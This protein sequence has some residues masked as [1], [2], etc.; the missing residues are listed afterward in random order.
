MSR[1]PAVSVA[2]AMRNAE[3]TIALTLQSLLDQSLPDWELL[4]IDDGSSDSSL[5]IARRFDDPRILIRADG[6]RLGLAARLNE[7]V[8]ASRGPYIA[9][10]DADD[11]A[12]PERFAR[13]VGFLDRH[14]EVDLLGTAA[15]VFGDDGKVIGALPFRA[16][17]RE[18]AARP[19]AGFYLVHPTWMGRREWF[20]A[21]AYDP[22]SIKSQDYDLLLRSHATSRFACLPEILLGYRQ[23]RLSLGKILASR[24]Q[25]SRSVLRYGWNNKVFHR[26]V[27][28]LAGQAA[29]FA[30]DVLAVSSGLGYRM[31]RHRALAVAPDTRAEWLKVWQRLNREV[32]EKCAA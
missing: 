27:P 1:N 19:W 2:M 12:Y 8:A 25:T 5:A 24:I 3:S 6:R 30:I 20:N 13:Q 11:V 29:K 16:S 22:R 14:P 21:H 10:M 17:H 32:D 15:I 7:A 31:L 23:E 9:R 4:L 26:V 28:A 18:I